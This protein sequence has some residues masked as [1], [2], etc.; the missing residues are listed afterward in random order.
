MRYSRGL[1][2]WIVGLAVAMAVCRAA[3]P[4]PI[5]PNLLW[6]TCE[7]M[8]PDL[9]CY[10]SR[11]AITPNIDRLARE[12][13]LYTRAFATAPACSPARSC[14][15]SGRYATTLG[16]P[17]L[18][19]DFPVP[20]AVT[21]FPSRLRAAGYYCCGCSCWLPAIVSTVGGRCGCCCV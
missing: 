2:G 10:G 14:L 15:I 13:V 11:Y 7:D 8:G 18:R 5:R 21:G 12:G 6:I 19:S 16:T 3:D 4:A 1:L 17:H 9:G 20:S